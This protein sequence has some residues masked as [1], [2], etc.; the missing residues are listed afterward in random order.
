M[1]T[2][3]ERPA[4]D[5]PV[6][7]PLGPMGDIYRPRQ[8]RGGSKIDIAGYRQILVW[9]FVLRLDDGEAIRGGGRERIEEAIDAAIDA[10]R[11][12]DGRD[13]NPEGP[14]W[15]EILDLLDH[16]G[17]PKQ[18]LPGAGDLWEAAQNSAQ[19]YGEF[20]YF[21]D[22]LQKALF[23]P[24]PGAIRPPFRVWRRTD[25][26]ALEV[27]LDHWTGRRHHTARVE[28]FN[29][30]L[31]DVG[32]AVAV[33]ELDFGREVDR[34]VGQTENREPIWEKS[35]ATLA[36][37]Q[38]AVDQV[39]RVYTPFFYVSTK[40]SVPAA[41]PLPSG[42]P[43]SVSWR[44][45]S[46][47]LLRDTALDAERAKRPAQ[48]G[49]KVH[50]PPWT[51]ESLDA[52]LQRLRPGES[53][54]RRRDDGEVRRRRTSPLADHWRQALRPL[55]FAGYHPD[56]D[57]AAGEEA[58][59][60]VWRHILD[61]RIPVMSYVS[62]T[63][64]AS[65]PDALG[66]PRMAGARE[67]LWLVSRGDWARL[68]AADAPGTDTLPYAPHFL[69]DFEK[70]HCYDRFFP[71]DHT[72]TATRYLFSGY[73]FSV[74]GAGEYFDG[75]IAHHFRRHYFQMALL[76]NMELAALLATSSRIT[77]AV[78]RLEQRTDRQGR[79]VARAEFR[80]ELTSIQEDFL[81]FVHR[82]R[83]TDVSNQIQ[84]SELYRMWRRSMRIDGLYDDVKDELAAAVG[85][86]MTLEQAETA[87]DAARLSAVA[88]VG[89]PLALTFSLLP[90]FSE[91]IKNTDPWAAGRGEAIEKAVPAVPV[92][93]VG[94]MLW[95]MLPLLVLLVMSV[96][97]TAGVLYLV[98]GGS[99]GPAHRPSLRSLLLNFGSMLAV[100]AAVVLGF[101]LTR[102][103]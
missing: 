14:V 54:G 50:A 33:I 85:F 73:H 91:V 96:F 55:V 28:R 63:G 67:D 61:E 47:G 16:A 72:D 93:W 8:W 80:D 29:L 24:A 53:K 95:A 6:D 69:A 87:R 89:V 90:V 43:I 84:P 65:G 9:P 4:N 101:V 78:A 46:G 18:T 2:A 75:L 41:V 40:P 45:T 82:F 12:A 11:R 97:T 32:A 20:V 35:N 86:A 57:R 98:S 19:T 59:K 74:V 36:D 37:V 64:A 23:R 48:P 71:S 44:K 38:L 52:A 77:E 15:E 62:L 42:C 13:G 68:C 22:F 76:A 31:F 58:P 25:V 102:A 17:Q 92:D 51:P 66:V 88:T 26:M 70:E 27:V 7:D 34:M 103:H 83:F 100:A 94:S 99:K 81:T 60:A 56:V 3:D 21:Y 5:R 30:Y 49:D 79:A 39:R 10:L 1:T